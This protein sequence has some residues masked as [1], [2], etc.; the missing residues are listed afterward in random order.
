MSVFEAKLVDIFCLNQRIECLS[1]KGGL[2][3]ENKWMI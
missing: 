3:K 2:T 1:N